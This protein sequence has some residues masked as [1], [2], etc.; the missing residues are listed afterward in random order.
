[1]LFQNYDL[2][3]I[4]SY[5][6]DVI[7]I[8][9]TDGI[10]V[11]FS[12]TH[13]NNRLAA[14]SHAFARMRTAFCA[15]GSPNGAFGFAN[16]V[17]WY[18]AEKI[19]V[20]DAPSLNWG[21]EVNQVKEI[22]RLTTLLRCHPAFFDQA[23]IRMIQ[24]GPGNQIV[25][26]RRHGP[27]GKRLLIPVNLDDALGTTARW[28]LRESG[29]DQIAPGAFV[30]LL[31][32]E[33]IDI[34]RDGRQAT[35]ALEPGQVRCLSADP[36]D[37]RLVEKASGR[38][39]RLPE[40]IEH[41]KRRAKVLDI[42]RHC[43]EA[44]DPDDF[45]VDRAAA[46]LGKDPCRF[47][48]SISPRGAEPRLITWQWPQDIERDVMVPPGHF[49]MVRSASPF[50]AD[51]TDSGG[52]IAREASLGQSDG[53][54]FAVFSPLPVPDAFRRVTL[55]IS[56]FL[57][58]ENRRRESSIRYLPKAE[59]VL[60]RTMYPRSCLNNSRLLFLAT[61]GRGGMCRAP[62]SWG[63]LSSRYDALLAGNLNPEIP[64][65]RW[66]M[67]ARCRAWI[68]FQDYSQELCE[69]CL[70]LFSLDGSEGTWHF[71]VPTGQGEHVRL[72]IGL[73]MI[74]GKNE[75]RLIFYRCPSGGLDGRLGDEKPLRLIVRPDIES[76]NF[77]HVTKAFTGPEHH[78]PSAIEKHS[79]GFTFAPD[80]YHR[81]RVEMPQG[82]FVWEP[83]W[84]YM[85][86]RSV[87]SERG[88]DPNSDLFSPGYFDAQ[89][90][91]GETV[92]LQAAIG[93]SSFEP[94]FSAEKHRQ[95]E[96][97][98]PKDDHRTMKVSLSSALSSALTHYIVKR[99]DLKSI[100][101]GYPWFLDWGRDALIVVR[102]MIA[103]DRLEA[104][105]AVLKQFARFED[106]GTLPNM[107]HG[108]SAGNRDTSDAPLWL[109]VACRDLEGREGDSFLNEKCADRSIRKILLDIG[110]H[111][112]AGTPNG[113]RMDAESGL[114]Y[115]PM[116]FTWMD[117]NFPAGTPRQGYPIEIQALWYA[118]LDYL[119]RIDSTGLWEKT[120]SRVKAS[121]LELFC[122]KKEAYLS[123][124]LHSRAGGAP[125]KAEPDDAL[126]P[127]QLFAVT[128]GAVSEKKVCRQVVSA[129]QELLVPGAIR[130]LADRPVRRPLPIHH[131]GKI[132]NDPHR[133]FQGRYEGDEDSSRKPA[134]H[135]GTAWTWVFPSFCEAWVL[136]YGA[137]AKETARSWLASCAPMLD[138]GCIGHVP[139][140][141]D[142]NA[143]HAQRGCDAQAWG[144]S[145]FLRVLKLLEKG[146]REKGM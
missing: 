108:E 59:T 72:S 8:S 132:V 45:H 56:V 135:N 29:I 141:L 20:H 60:V 5:L 86:F 62:L 6:P 38:F 101:A 15:L 55:K 67:L 75:V 89:V 61:N 117:T 88:L 25:L 144:A 104:A 87:E 42:L 33:R 110:N 27:S 140:I 80:P 71:Q 47:F 138:E 66:I 23:E 139:E 52:T 130:T 32:G 146:C 77:H 14:R 82:R 98:S 78:F 113:I 63:K 64:E 17:E 96:A 70:E 43:P 119:G 74:P 100:V 16:G 102:G 30:D 18:A 111:Y 22:R 49:L 31:T 40:R 131:Q 145:E 90:K 21:A 9:R 24:T 118:A 133:P 107:I 69:S 50:Y 114:I 58:G 97:C 85:V 124:C 91:G 115:S 92:D 39:L 129:C 136:A 93:E 68:I 1:E 35:C 46:E 76:R 116:H 51:L 19:D 103:D 120:A 142:G 126:R 81:L 12:E 109:I 13:D 48:R 106:R 99:G 134:Y 122:L 44:G 127:N 95:G 3:Q 125:E 36:E 83:E 53:T 128:L 54:F 137:G 112:I 123:D 143:P 84:L 10:L 2:S 11:N 73:K 121:I 4:E 28:D 34:R 94:S 65:D 26:L 79:N 57:E 105:R 7:E 41:Q 37:I